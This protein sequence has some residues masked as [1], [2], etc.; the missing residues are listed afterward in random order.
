M[1]VKEKA[2]KGTF[3]VLNAARAVKSSL[4]LPPILRQGL[5]V[6]LTNPRLSVK[7]FR[8]AMRAVKS[9]ES[10]ARVG[11]H[12]GSIASLFA[13]F[14]VAFDVNGVVGF[15]ARGDLEFYVD[16][17]TIHDEWEIATEEQH[18]QRLRKFEENH[19]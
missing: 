2:L 4:D 7:A 18:E 6:T 12:P 9:P 10:Q 11:R 8:K 17:Q 3:E 14:R 15:G 13:S 19:L 5:L 16:L 1:S